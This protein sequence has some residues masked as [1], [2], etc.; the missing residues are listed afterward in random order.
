MKKILII[1]INYL[2]KYIISKNKLLQ[3]N[4][5]NNLNNI[6]NNNTY[7]EIPN[8][9]KILPYLQNIN[10]DLPNNIKDLFYLFGISYF[11]DFTKLTNKII[12][13]MLNN[14]DKDNVFDVNYE[15]GNNTD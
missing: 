15:S 12:D 3:A 9:N 8:F 1:I 10:T 2:S 4:Y 5:F 7:M 6:N 11:I 13:Y 14:I